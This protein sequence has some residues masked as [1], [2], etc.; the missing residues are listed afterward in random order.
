G[1]RLNDVFPDGRV[2]RVTFGVLN[3]THRDSHEF[4]KPVP[5]GRRLRVRVPL[6]DIAYS[7]RPGHRLRTAISTTYWPMVWP[8]PESV[9]LRLTTRTSVLE[10]PV[11]RR[12]PTDLRVAFEPPEQGPPT[13]KT[14]LE[15]PS[16]SRIIERDVGLGTVT[17]RAE[18]NEGRAV[19]AETGVEIG[20][21]VSE[22]LVITEDDPLR[23]VTE[24]GTA[25]SYGKGAW[26]TKVHGRCAL[27]ATATQWL[28]SA[29]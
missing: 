14:V 17:I 25:F 10:L 6:N 22:R 5:A 18:E 16:A 13:A 8:A 24:M 19:I 1:V 23:A 7:F 28:L 9:T 3:L 11:R 26:R 4:P 12:R 2:S 15:P 21:W 20:R 29:D 27:R